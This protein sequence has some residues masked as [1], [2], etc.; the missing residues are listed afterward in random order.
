MSLPRKRNAAKVI[1]GPTPMEL[2]VLAHLELK[3]RRLRTELAEIEDQYAQ[4]SREIGLKGIPI[5]WLDRPLPLGDP[6]PPAACDLSK[7]IRRYPRGIQSMSVI[8]SRVENR[9]S[10]GSLPVVIRRGFRR[11][12]SVRFGL[13]LFPVPAHRT[14]L[15][16]FPHPALGK[17]SRPIHR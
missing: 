17:D 1:P 2:R 8:E 7:I 3:R 5:P 15:A 14:G 6:K 9:R 13:V 16:D 10:D 12:T 11:V 4:F